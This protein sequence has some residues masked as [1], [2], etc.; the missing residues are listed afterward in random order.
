MEC[1]VDDF[2]VKTRKREEH[3]ADL[4]MVFNCLKK[5]NIKMNP[6][7]CAFGVTS[8]K[9]LGF[10][11]RHRGIKIDSAKVDAIQKMP[12]PRNLKELQSLQGNLAFIR[13][14]ISNLAG[15]F[16]LFNHLMKKDVPFQ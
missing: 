3:L 14:F 6:L 13:R 4:Q 12:P 1:Y 8:G 10:I 9:F 2:V 7:K 11:V 16:Q 15:R 5:Y